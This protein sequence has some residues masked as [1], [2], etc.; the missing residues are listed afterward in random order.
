MP[1]TYAENVRKIENDD[2]RRFAEGAGAD[3]HQSV[4]IELVGPKVSVRAARPSGRHPSPIRPFEI[5]DLGDDSEQVR[6]MDRLGA[7]LTSLGLGD[8]EG[9]VRLDSARAF[10]AEVTP[11]QLRKV[12][13]SPLVEVIRP[14]R[15]RRSHRR[16]G[17]PSAP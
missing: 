1:K 17:A 15:E 2:L 14:N 7:Q 6:D 12:A 10:V 11:S 9:L 5:V 3:T 16:A 8:G 4:I 13:D